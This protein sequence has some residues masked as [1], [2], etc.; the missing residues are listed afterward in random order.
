[1]NSIGEICDEIIKGG[2]GSGRKAKLTISIKDKSIG[3]ILDILSK[4]AMTYNLSGKGVVIDAHDSSKNKFLEK[5]MNLA[6]DY[7]LK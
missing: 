1:M 7:S 6:N 5:I 4:N 2:P 3:G